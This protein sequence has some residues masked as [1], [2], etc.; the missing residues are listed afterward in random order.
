VSQKSAGSVLAMLQPQMGAQKRPPFKDFLQNA[1]IIRVWLTNVRHN[2]A[3]NILSNAT[4]INA[5]VASVIVGFTIPIP[6]R[7]QMRQRSVWVADWEQLSA[8][9]ALAQFQSGLLSRW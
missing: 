7:A 9:D 4:K 8:F 1:V 2:E 3:L 5:Q 6:S